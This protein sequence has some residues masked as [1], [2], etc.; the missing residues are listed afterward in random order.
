MTQDLQPRRKPFE[1]AYAL[2]AH[3]G[4]TAGSPDGQAIHERI[5]RGELTHAQGVA[6]AVAAARARAGS[7]EPPPPAS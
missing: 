5:R 7:A 1:L 3:E 2:L 6:L 4:L